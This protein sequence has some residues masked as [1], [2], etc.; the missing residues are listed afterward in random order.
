MVSSPEATMLEEG[1]E[2]R[3]G[4]SPTL[5]DRL[6]EEEE[7]VKETK[8]EEAKVEETKP[9]AT[10]EEMMKEVDE[11]LKEF[12]EEKEANEEVKEGSSGEGDIR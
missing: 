9:V 11:G 7:G 10:V 3:H 6:Q 12:K 1:G 4:S 2:P 8:G 5:E